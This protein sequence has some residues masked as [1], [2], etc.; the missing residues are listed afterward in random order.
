MGASTA[1]AAAINGAVC[2]ADGGLAGASIGVGTGDEAVPLDGGAIGDT[3]VT[4]DGGGATD[5]VGEGADAVG[6]CRN[7][8]F[9]PLSFLADRPEENRSDASKSNKH[10]N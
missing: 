3:V 6:G 9:R 7:G 5:S 10:S 1:G 4:T 8:T 2:N